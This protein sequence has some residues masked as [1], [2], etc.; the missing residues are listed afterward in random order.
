MRDYNWHRL[1]QQIFKAL[2]VI[3]S[4][5]LS[6]FMRSTSLEITVDKGPFCIVSW[7]LI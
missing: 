1:S 6:E 7:L 2:E 3:I 4:G 5:L